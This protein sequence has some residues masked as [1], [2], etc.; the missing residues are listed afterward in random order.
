MDSRTASRA[1]RRTRGMPVAP[2]PKPIEP[3]APY[4]DRSDWQRP[5]SGRFWVL[6]WLGMMALTAL[7]VALTIG[8]R[9]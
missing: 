1:F 6:L 9:P 5:L 7:G 4:V 8:W 2:P 3:L